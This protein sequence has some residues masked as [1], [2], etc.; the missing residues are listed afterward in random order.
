[1]VKFLKSN[2]P[3]IE[4]IGLGMLFYSIKMTIVYSLNQNSTENVILAYL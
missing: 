2:D 4:F 1:M 3:L